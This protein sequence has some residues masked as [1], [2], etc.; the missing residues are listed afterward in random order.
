MAGVIARRPTYAELT[1]LAICASILAAQLFLPP[2]IG[3]ADNGDFP[4]VAGPLSLGPKDGPANFIH[5]VP[6]YLRSPRYYWNSQTLL[7]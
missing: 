3:L 2:F 5:F 6:D 4:K 7:R 1:L